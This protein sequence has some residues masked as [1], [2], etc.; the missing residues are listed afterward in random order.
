MQ[1]SCR[2]AF[3]YGEMTDRASIAKIEGSLEN[4]EQMQVEILLYKKNSELFYS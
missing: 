3:M 4:H 2:C 1:K